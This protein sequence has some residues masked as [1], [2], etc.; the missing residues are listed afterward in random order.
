[1]HKNQECNSV[2]FFILWGERF[3]RKTPM[4]KSFYDIPHIARVTFVTLEI[5]AKVVD[6][7]ISLSSQQ[8]I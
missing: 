6:T 1:V 4:K 8:T 5:I 3:P 2:R 7:Y